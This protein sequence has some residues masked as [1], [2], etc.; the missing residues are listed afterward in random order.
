MEKYSIEYWLAHTEYVMGNKDKIDIDT[1][2]ADW[3]RNNME[4]I[5]RNEMPY[6][7]TGTN[8]AKA[9]IQY[10]EK[11]YPEKKEDIVKLMSE[12][13]KSLQTVERPLVKV[14]DFYHNLIQ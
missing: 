1:S 3:T 4:R 5:F 11:Y 6:G 12:Y 10:V 13:I 14:Y 9:L 7:M 8:G 2:N